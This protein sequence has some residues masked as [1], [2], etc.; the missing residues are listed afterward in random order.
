MHLREPS[1]VPGQLVA[2][3]QLVGAVGDTGNASGCHLH[4]EL[5]EGAY[6]GGGAPSTRA[7]PHLAGPG[8]QAG[9]PPGRIA[10]GRCC[11]A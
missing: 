5:W 6:Y 7:L 10:K 1:V 11:G 3:G 8:T 2:A 9:C 4:F